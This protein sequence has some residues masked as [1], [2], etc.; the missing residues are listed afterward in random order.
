M[1]VNLYTDHGNLRPKFPY[2]EAIISI[3]IPNTGEGER[4]GE[5]YVPG[6]RRS[7]TPAESQ[8]IAITGPI[9]CP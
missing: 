4:A 9:P 8:V 3:F 5:S 6:Y 1:D 7:G 2:N